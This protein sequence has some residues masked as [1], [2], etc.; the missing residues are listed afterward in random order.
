MQMRITPVVLN[1]MIINGLVFLAWQLLPREIMNEY[2]L[3]FKIDGIPWREIKNFPY[4]FMPLQ[5]VTTFFSHQD[6][7]HIVFNMYA[8]F[9][10]GTAVETTIGS[11]RFLIQYL[12]FGIVSG[13]LIAVLDPSANPVLGASTAISGLLVVYAYLFPNSRM[14]LLFLPFQFKASQ[15][16]IGW[17]VISV[18]LLIWQTVDPG[19]GITISHFGHLM[20]MLVAFVY[21]NIPKLR[22]LL[23]GS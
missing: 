4:E 20:G 2:F 8:L 11:R 9:L 1:L 10:F 7:M 21:L 5:I 19:E 3:L 14:G 12:V 23:S 15:F 22:K 13:I 6:V 18:G 16:V 17:A